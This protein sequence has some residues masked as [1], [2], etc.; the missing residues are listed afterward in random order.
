MAI[1]LPDP[2]PSFAV[3]NRK[4]RDESWFQ[5]LRTRDDGAAMTKE[6]FIAA[7]K[8]TTPPRARKRTR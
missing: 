4:L 5:Q 7:R 3:P 2:H 1:I 8:G 6:E